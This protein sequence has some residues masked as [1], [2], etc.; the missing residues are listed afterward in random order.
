M[1]F[2]RA[3]RAPHHPTPRT[4]LGIRALLIWLVLSLALPF[5]LFA[6]WGLYQGFDTDRAHARRLTEDL[7]RLTAA[8]LDDHISNL[9]VGLATISHTVPGKLGDTPAAVTAWLAAL[10]PELPSEF[11]NFGIWRRDGSLLGS[12]DAR[13]VHTGASVAGQPFFQRTIE[14]GSLG[15]DAPV[16]S[17]LTGRWVALLAVPVREHGHTVAVVSASTDLERL[18]AIGETHRSLPP[19]AVVTVVDLQGTVLARSL[20]AKRWI[21]RQM[22]PDTALLQQ[23]QVRDRGAVDMI[24][25]FDATERMT[26][27]AAMHKAPWLV[28]VGI[29]VDAALAPAQQRLHATAGLAAIMLFLSVGAAAW[30]AGRLTRPL[31]Q[32]GDSVEA[33]G[34]GD[35][36]P[37]APAEGPKELRHLR[38]AFAGMSAALAQRTAAQQQSE[39]LLRELTDH[40]PALISVVNSDG[41]LCFANRAYEDWLGLPP[42]RLT[43]R[44]LET[45]YGAA[46]YRAIQPYFARAFA[47]EAVVYERTMA[48]LSGDRHVEVKLVPRQEAG[49][50][51]GVFAMITDI[52]DQRVSQA[53]LA[54]SEERLSLAMESSGLA[55]FDWNI[56]HNTVYHSAQAAVMRGWPASDVTTSPAASCLDWVHPDDRQPL[57][58]RLRAVIRGRV[59]ALRS[60]HRVLTHSGTWCW[61]LSR[62]RV[63]ERDA[64]GHALRLAGIHADV[65][66]RHEMEDRLR[67]L[68]EVDPLTGL[69]NRRVFQDRLA[70][71][72]QRAGRDRRAL[73]L[74]FLDIDRF[75]DVNDTFG[76][77]AGD[78]VLKT[79]ATRLLSS[80]RPGDTVARLAGDEFTVI[81]E[82]F[83]EPAA[84]PVILQR[85]ASAI[86]HDV[87]FAGR[88]WPVSASIGVAITAAD[89]DALPDG[90]SLLRQADM[91]LYRAK[92]Q[93]RGHYCIVQQGEPPDES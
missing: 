53:R 70:L 62:G 36:L 41:T 16:R 51:T 69:P 58:Q 24:K 50:I 75:K 39:R 4:A 76:H 66:V 32:L 38:D 72:L 45:L 27:F 46:V 40:L 57:V 29:P 56:A 60:E 67:Q 77:E 17:R 78:E 26:G 44:P 65:T 47:G 12:L 11:H 80:V 81:L 33:M 83:G 42:D 71:A 74:L 88:P 73:A 31:R 87:H 92:H 48:M 93:G 23:M 79:C 82:D 90:A 54:L 10:G 20:D 63:V 7:A 13:L 84:V 15:L 6:G 89:G 86:G 18:P 64:A 2:P 30:F 49:R 5:S 3:W 91:A 34:R 22:V 55:L 37:V 85:I 43:G 59:P 21:G 8:R 28:F 1:K 19:G 68:A 61:V 9:Q 14:T 35:D 52:T 25:G